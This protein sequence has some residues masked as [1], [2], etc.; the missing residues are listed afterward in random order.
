MANRASAAPQDPAALDRAARDL[1]AIAVNCQREQARLA[2]WSAR[3][4]PMS[5][6][7]RAVI[8]QSATGE[9]RTMSQ[10]LDRT[11]ARLQKSVGELHQ[12]V[13]LARQLADQARRH[14]EQARAQQAQNQRGQR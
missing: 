1:E 9:D 6:R 10:H 7:T 11:S 8:G 12:A 2:E 3:V 4:A 14:A 13:I 5:E